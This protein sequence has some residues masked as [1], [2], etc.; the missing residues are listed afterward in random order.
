[1]TGDASGHSEA[2]LTV[3]DK[4]YRTILDG[5][6]PIVAEIVNSKQ[7]RGLCS[8]GELMKD[9]RVR[10]KIAA[11]PL[12]YDRKLSKILKYY[13]DYFAILE[14]G[15]SVATCQAYETGL[16][17]PNTNERTAARAICGADSV[18]SVGAGVATK[19]HASGFC[20]ASSWASA[21]SNA[22]AW[23]Q[24]EYMVTNLA[25]TLRSST[26]TEAA[27]RQQFE[28]LLQLRHETFALTEYNTKPGAAPGY[29]YGAAGAQQH[30]SSLSCGSAETRGGLGGGILASYA[31]AVTSEANLS[32]PTHLTPDEKEEKI[33]MLGQACVDFLAQRE[34]PAAPL[35][36]LAQHPQI[37]ALKKSVIAKFERWL[38]SQPQ[39]FL[40]SAEGTQQ[41]LWVQLVLYPDERTGDYTFR[42]NKTTAPGDAGY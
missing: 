19:S 20:S 23:A 2:E 35:N 30:H 16:L 37:I 3:E 5:L 42:P 24:Y 12:G 28:E 9:T 34:P 40:V 26:A 21:A 13:D 38:R 41:C 11:I 15:N 17:D 7:H 6:I 25:G 29:A 27:L 1:M 31:H 39:A 10:E 32:G 4:E 18:G 14:N 36:H 33:N 8:M 22:E